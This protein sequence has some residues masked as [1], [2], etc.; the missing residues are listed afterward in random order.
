MPP[1]WQENSKEMSPIPPCTRV[2][3]RKYNTL[4][5][6]A[7]KFFIVG[8]F[9][10]STLGGFYFM[11]VLEKSSLGNPLYWYSLTG[12]FYFGFTLYC[13]GVTS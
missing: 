3:V 12:C 11:Y 8:Q 4:L 5:S 2:S 9:I 10:Y 7:W 6:P 13:I 1:G